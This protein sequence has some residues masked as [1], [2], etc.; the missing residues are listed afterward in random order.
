MI[1]GIGTDIIEVERVKKAFT[2][3]SF[4]TRFFSD[5][6]IDFLKENMQS[7][8]SNFAAKESVAK[9]FGTGFRGFE[10]KEIEV[11]RNELGAPYIVLN[12]KAKDKAIEL[13]IDRFHVSIS[14]IKSYAIAYV[15][16]ERG[17][18]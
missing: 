5:G 11:L 13:G 12:G 4:L 3:G 17:D 9:A 8:A 16:A 2:T 7:I 6:E 10:M 18:N 14:N 15:I 1:V